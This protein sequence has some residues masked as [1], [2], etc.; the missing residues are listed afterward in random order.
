[1]EEALNQDLFTTR[2]HLHF[3]G[4]GRVSVLAYRRLA[5]LWQ[6]TA[7]AHTGWAVG[8][9]GK[10]WVGTLTVARRL[11]GECVVEAGRGVACTD[12]VLFQALCAG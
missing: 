1:M 7:G 5:A 8:L 3:I 12:V 9:H 6:Q 11:L 4:D 2:R 10:V